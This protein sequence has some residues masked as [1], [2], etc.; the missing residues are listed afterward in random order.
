MKKNRIRATSIIAILFVSVFL[1]LGY[2]YIARSDVIP[3]IVSGVI[4]LCA[5]TI[6]LSERGL[7]QLL[8]YEHKA[9]NLGLNEKD[10]KRIL[11]NSVFSLANVYFSVALASIIPLFQYEIWFVTVFPII[12]ISIIPIKAVADEYYLFTHKR[13]VFWCINIFIIVFL[14]IL[15]QTII[16]QFV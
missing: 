3:I 5:N 6:A 1:F 10:K 12:L 4:I 16:W 13:G 8:N 15:G 9:V 11:L 7:K 14:Q 2:R